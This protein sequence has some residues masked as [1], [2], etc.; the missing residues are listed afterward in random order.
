MNCSVARLDIDII[1]GAV[2]DGMKQIS[3]VGDVAIHVKV[4]AVD[5]SVFRVRMEQ[6]LVCNR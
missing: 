3:V 1:G 2:F 6:S 5:G 4:V